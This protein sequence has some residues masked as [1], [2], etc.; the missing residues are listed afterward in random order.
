MKHGFLCGA[1]AEYLEAVRFFEDQRAGL[2]ASHISEFARIV[3]LATE[4]PMT[5]KLVYPTGIRCIGLTKFPYSV[6]FRVLTDGRIQVTAF[7][8]HRRRPG[9]WLQRMGV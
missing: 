2:G 4:R 9:Y 5:W 3:A 1:E 7:A 6:F 8:H